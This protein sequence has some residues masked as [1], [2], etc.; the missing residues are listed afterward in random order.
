MRAAAMQ[1]RIGGC[2]DRTPWCWW[3]SSAVWHSAVSAGITNDRDQ[4]GAHRFSSHTLKTTLSAFTPVV[5]AGCRRW[6]EGTRLAERCW[7]RLQR[8]RTGCAS[9]YVASLETQLSRRPHGLLGLLWSAVLAGEGL[10]SCQ[11]AFIHP[12]TTGRVRGA[13]VVLRWCLTAQAAS[14]WWK[15]VRQGCEKRWWGRQLST[16][17]SSATAPQQASSS[18]AYNVEQRRQAKKQKTKPFAN[19][20]GGMRRTES[21]ARC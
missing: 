9:W 15:K 8:W 19:G 12:R 10:G 16:R 7:Q 4:I 1:C 6:L 21:E 18:C 14:W 2:R 5:A 13:F 11:T 3:C 17:P 20:G